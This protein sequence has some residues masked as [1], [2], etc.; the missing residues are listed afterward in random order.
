MRR[1]LREERRGWFAGASWTGQG[2]SQC[3]P[4]AFA[5]VPRAH[6]FAFRSWLEKYSCSHALGPRTCQA[7]GELQCCETA[8][9]DHRP[10]RGR[11]RGGGRNMVHEE[12]EIIASSSCS[13][14]RPVA[15]ETC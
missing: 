8:H 10:N 14:G 6:F 3:A 7:H 12:N 4:Q 2:I 1:E 13:T 5:I 9:C 11:E 15:Q